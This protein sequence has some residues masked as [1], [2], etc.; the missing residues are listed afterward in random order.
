MFAREHKN[1]ATVCPINGEYLLRL[2]STGVYIIQDT[3]R[4]GSR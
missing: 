4:F 3:Q 1:A 2:K